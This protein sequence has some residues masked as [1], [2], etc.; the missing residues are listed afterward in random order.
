MSEV[1]IVGSVAYDGLKTPYGS[2]PRT[3]GGAAT[4]SS[5]ASSL[6][7]KTHIVGVVGEDFHPNDLKLL[8]SK[9]IGLDGLI[10]AKG[11]TFYWKGFYKKEDMNIAYTLKTELN[12]FADFDPK[13]PEKDR[14]IPFLFLANIHPALQY[15]VTQQIH[16]PKFTLL[17]TMNLWIN[18]ARKDLLKVMTKVDLMVLN[19]QEVRL[20]TGE[21]HL[22]QAARAILKMGPKRVI[23]KKGEHGSMLVGPEGTFLSP[24]MPLDRVVDPTGAGDTFAGGFIGYLARLGKVDLE[25]LKQ[26][27]VAGTLTASFTVE[28]LGVKG[29]AG[30][31]LGKVRQRAKEFYR[32]ASLPTVKL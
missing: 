29:V 14:N 2:T 23:V 20:L 27:I 22:K 31:T 16:K 21:A 15:K 12:V 11:K 17:D 25:T 28:Q 6:Y 7:T 19:D 32:F 13:I 1:L 24:A 3:L 5:L 4:Y 9:N 26:A 18:I 8:K 10:R 30:L